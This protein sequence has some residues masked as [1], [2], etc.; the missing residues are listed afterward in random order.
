MT[1]VVSTDTN[2]TM[3]S[4]VIL[5]CQCGAVEFELK[6]SPFLTTACL[7]NSCRAAAACF[8]TLPGATSLL[9]A[10][11]ATATA[12]YRKDRVACVKGSEHLR[13]HRLTPE[14]TTRRVVATCCNSPMFMEFTKGHWIDFYSQRWP[15]G[16]APPPEMRTMVS[17]L[18][19]GTKLPGDLP[20]Y[21]WQSI[22][23]FA[24]LAAAW[25]AMGFRRPEISYV[26]GRLND[27]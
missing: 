8:A 21:R 10:H 20:N 6:G 25:I 22:G 11:E 18:P 19:V 14:T 27:C 2:S 23:L 4:I 26:K 24:K 9:D 12:A 17:D 5:S 1:D 16:S 7:C 3:K 15:A 13:E